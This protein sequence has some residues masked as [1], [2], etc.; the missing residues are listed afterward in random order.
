MTTVANGSNVKVH[1]V[2][3]YRESGEEFDNSHTR[4]EPIEFT[5]GS[6]QMISGFETAV[7]GMTEGDTKEVTI[8]P[9]DAYGD[10]RGELVNNFPKTNFP[11]DF[12]FT[13]GGY[14]QAN[15]TSG[16]TLFGKIKSVAD[17]QVEVDFN[18]PLAGE[19][20]NFKIELVSIG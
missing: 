19:T 18:H 10:Y 2:G 7:I 16:E 17:D 9:T 12:D 14:V 3:T 8:E 5:V 11:E 13:V 15:N 6:G 1:Y 4:G 20:I